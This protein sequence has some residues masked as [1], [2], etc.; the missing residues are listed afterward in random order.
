MFRP[1]QPAQRTQNY[2]YAIR[3]IVAEARKIEAQGKTVTYLNI[4]DPSLYGFQPPQELVEAAIAAMRSGHNGYSPSV[5]ISEAREAVAEE[6]QRRGIPTSPDNVIFTYGASEAA[7]LVFTALLEPGDEVLVPAPGYPLYTAIAAK[8]GAVEVRYRQNAENRWQPDADEL[9]RKISARTKLLVIINP[10]NPTG[11]LY[12]KETLLAMLQVAREHKLVVIAD[13]VYHK[14]I[15]EGV[16]VPIASLAGDDLP[17]MTMES[18]SKNYL[19]PGWRLGWMSITNA[20]LM[21]EL[22]A[23]IR[24]LADARLCAPMPPQHVIRTAMNL[25]AGYLEPT[26]ARLR[27]QRDLTFEALN[28]IPG[29]RCNKPEGAFYAMAQVDL[30][31]GELGTDEEFVLGLLREKGVLFVHGSGF[32][33]DP[34]EGFFRVVFLPDVHTLQAVYAKVAEFAKTFRETKAAIAAK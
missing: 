11:A 4:G 32:G 1:Y 13:E 26:L 30:E 14:L 18:L 2:H 21:P 17:V 27:Q 29:I 16:H 33:T 20:H 10:N 12:S 34:K 6:A 3:N 23:A 28:R 8:L 31:Q 7:D 9:R 15:F 24:K 5:G 19:A 22:I 25:P